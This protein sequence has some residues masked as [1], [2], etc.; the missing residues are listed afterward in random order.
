MKTLW[1]GNKMVFCSS[2]K[3][4]LMLFMAFVLAGPSLAKLLLGKSNRG[5]N[6]GPLSPKS[7]EVSKLKCDEKVYSEHCNGV[8]VDYNVKNKTTDSTKPLEILETL[9]NQL[10]VF[11]STMNEY[12]SVICNVNDRYQTTSLKESNNV[13]IPLFKVQNISDPLFSPIDREKIRLIPESKKENNKVST[14]A[15]TSKSNENLYINTNE[16]KNKTKNSTE[17]YGSG[18][19]FPKK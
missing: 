15:N 17:E 9:K 3:K 7:D 11:I 13:Q 8:N 14:S 18:P 12:S 4:A 5:D 1:T 19:N 10:N 16:D 6:S 2:A